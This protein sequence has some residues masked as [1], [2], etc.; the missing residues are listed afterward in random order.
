MCP[1]FLPLSFLSCLPLKPLPAT[2]P[3]PASL[4]PSVWLVKVSATVMHL[5][6]GDGEEDNGPSLVLCPAGQYGTV[7]SFL[8]LL[9]SP[10]IVNL[11][12][13]SFLEKKT[14]HHRLTP[15]TGQLLPSCRSQLK[16]HFL[17]QVF[18]DVSMRSAPPRCSQSFF[19]CLLITP[20]HPLYPLPLLFTPEPQ[21]CERR[22]KGCRGNP[23][24]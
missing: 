4:D 22:A 2:R 3:A 12:H 21:L 16:H 7:F 18:P 11:L 13:M 23:C 14:C 10:L 6:H 24:V 19:S 1:L 20:T 15:Q 9:F 5:S 17:R 8:T